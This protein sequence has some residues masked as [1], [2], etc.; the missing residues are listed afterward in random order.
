MWLH[1]YGRKGGGNF[2]G[3]CLGIDQ[4]VRY[5]DTLIPNYHTNLG[6]LYGNT[7]NTRVRSNLPAKVIQIKKERGGKL[8]WQKQ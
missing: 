8:Q 7:Q 6:F 2:S 1:P 5:M 3:V 4:A